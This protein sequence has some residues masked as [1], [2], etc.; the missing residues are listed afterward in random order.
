MFSINK[1]R[2]IKHAIYSNEQQEWDSIYADTVELVVYN[3]TFSGCVNNTESKINFE[4]T[5]TSPHLSLHTDGKEYV[6]GD[7]GESKAELYWL[8]KEISDFLG[9]ELLAVNSSSL[10]NLKLLEEQKL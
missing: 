2:R 9:L 4:N 7:Q 3:D 1:N 6:I 5:K 8:G 10:P